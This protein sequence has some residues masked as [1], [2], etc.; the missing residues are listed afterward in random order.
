MRVAVV[1]HVEWVEFARVD[2]VPEAGQIIHAQRWW[3]EP[4]GGGAVAAV[5]LRK[6]AGDCCFFT[7]LARDELGERC[8][9]G[10]QGHGVRVEV[11]WRDEQQRRK[12]A[13]VD[14]AGERTLTVLGSR[15]VPLGA[16]SLPWDE[17][18]S[19][20]AVYFTG[21]DAAAL[22]AARGARVL[23]ATPRAQ[24]V[25]GEAGVAIDVLVGSGSDEGERYQPGEISPEPRIVVTTAGARGGTWKG[26]DGESG[27][28]PAAGLPGPVADAYG[29][30]DSFAAGLTFGLAGGQPLEAGL[31]L[32]A[33][34]GAHAM[35]G[36]G[37]VSGQL[38]LTG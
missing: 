38:S 14:A 15:L 5:Q 16:D 12:V 30:G 24:P 29:C 19:F 11:A 3:D 20:D 2:R 8:L 35:T 23:V 21:G 9:A 10:L 36:E 28:Y 37:A 7:A 6:L 13:F 33:K 34:C 32:A 4:G 1:G 22:R 26:S 31:A 25:L 17:L 18:A 27:A